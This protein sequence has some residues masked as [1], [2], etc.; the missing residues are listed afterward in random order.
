MC[1]KQLVELLSVLPLL[2]H[3]VFGLIETELFTESV[4]IQVAVSKVIRSFIA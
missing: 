1:L 2:G 3:V 4:Y